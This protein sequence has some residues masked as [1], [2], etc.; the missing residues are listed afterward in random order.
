MSMESARHL[1]GDYELIAQVGHGRTARVYEAIHKPSGERVAVKLFSPKLTARPDFDADFNALTDTLRKLDH[2]NILP[3]RDAGNQQNFY[4]IV[5]PFLESRGVDGLLR[6]SGRLDAPTALGI[7]QQAAAALD[8]ADQQGV[9]HGGLTPGNLLIDGGTI[10]VSDF[11]FAGLFA[12]RIKAAGGGAVALVGSPNTMAPEL[13]SDSKPTAASDRYSL[14]ATLYEM[15]TGQPPYTADDPSEVI[16]QHVQATIPSVLAVRPDLPEAVDPVIAAA[17]SKSPFVRPNSAGE[18]ALSLKDALGVEPLPLAAVPAPRTVV[19]TRTVDKRSRRRSAGTIPMW[20]VMGAV[21]GAAIVA[22]L[23][24]LLVGRAMWGAPIAGPTPRPSP[25]QVSNV[26]IPTDIV[27]PITFEAPPTAQDTPSPAPTPT[28]RNT[29]TP[30]PTFTP[31]LTE[32]P[33]ATITLTPTITQT[34]RITFTPGPTRTPVPTNDNPGGGGGG[35]GVLA[36]PIPNQ[37]YTPGAVFTLGVILPQT[38][39]PAPISASILFVRD[40]QLYAIHH[41]GTGLMQITSTNGQQAQPTRAAV[42][43][44]ASD[45]DGNWEIYLMGANGLGVTRLTNNNATDTEPSM[46]RDGSIAFA[47]TRSGGTDIYVIGTDGTLKQI[48]NHS[49]QDTSPSWSQDGKKL[50]FASNRDGGDFDLFSVNADGTGLKQ[51]T[52]TNAD[53]TAPAWS[54]DG[55]RIAYISGS[56]V[57]V[58]DVA[59]GVSTRLTTSGSAVSLSWSIDGSQIVYAS[60]GDLYVIGSS[61]GSPVRI[62]SG[63]AQDSDPAWAK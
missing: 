2:P 10:R 55:S 15:L 46:S 20:A 27:T 11:G 25:T 9:V 32:T 12:R 24:I 44:F 30:R 8:Y 26:G 7:I 1:F 31:V 21:V 5:T 40:G 33:T 36:T 34:P 53:E 13:V 57:Y 59:S 43:A 63:G 17:M 35:G 45:R 56:S 28:L 60:G 6:A 49:A 29:F 19:E 41:D 18:I 47:S 51:I 62:T 52:K 38:P 14:G 16:R 48:T 50:V 61:G 3:I 23:V 58:L 42:I 22:G 4:Y 39:A 37:T 54:P